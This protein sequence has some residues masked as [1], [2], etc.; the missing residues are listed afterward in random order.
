M[1][2]NYNKWGK[3]AATQNRNTYSLSMVAQEMFIVKK[4]SILILKCGPGNI[5]CPRN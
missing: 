5:N 2:L 3:A 1:C 4:F